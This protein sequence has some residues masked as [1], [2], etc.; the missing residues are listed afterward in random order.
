VSYLRIDP[1]GLAHAL[2]MTPR[3][4][5]G[6]ATA[7]PVPLRPHICFYCQ[8]EDAGLYVDGPRPGTRACADCDAKQAHS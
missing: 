1:K 5:S 7:K 2:D 4:S 6:R 8:T 3:T